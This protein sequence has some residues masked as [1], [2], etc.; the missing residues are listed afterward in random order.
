MGGF[1][2]NEKMD[3]IR[4]TT[5]AL[6][7]CVEAFDDSPEIGMEFGTP[8]SRDD[9]FP[10]FCCEDEVVM[11][12]GVGR[13]HDE[14]LL[15][16]LPGCGFRGVWVPVVSLCSTN[17]YKMG[18]LRHQEAASTDRRMRCVRFRGAPVAGHFENIPEG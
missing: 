4:N 13:G 2:G 9:G 14:R 5:Y 10:I 12:G 3:V 11:K 15:A 7:L 17:G 1:E 6:W 8:R 16:P 18:C